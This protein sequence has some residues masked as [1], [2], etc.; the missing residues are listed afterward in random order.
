MKPAN[1]VGGW[2]AHKKTSFT[3]MTCKWFWQ[4]HTIPREK[5]QITMELQWL[6]FKKRWSRSKKMTA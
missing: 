6:L 1:D 3:N 2:S 5:A 4:R